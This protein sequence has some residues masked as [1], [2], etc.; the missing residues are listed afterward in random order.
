MKRSMKLFSV[1]ALLA[2]MLAGSTARAAF[3]EW[4]Y[5]WAPSAT[6]VFAG[7]VG[8]GVENG[9]DLSNEPS[10]TVTGSSDIVA[11]NIDGFSTAPRNDPAIFGGRSDFSLKLQLTDKDSGA[12][13]DLT[14]GGKFTGPISSESADIDLTYTTPQTLTAILGGNE[15]TVTIGPYS[16]PGPPGSSNS[17]SI[18]AHVDV[19]EATIAEAPEPSTMLLS[20]VGLSIVGVASWRKRRRLALENC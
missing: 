11:T 10:G 4:T 3:I 17:G 20:C 16:P 1:G 15:Y 9:V 6:K 19:K 8:D 2:L 18:A 5:N 14:F 7:E 12:T 13:T